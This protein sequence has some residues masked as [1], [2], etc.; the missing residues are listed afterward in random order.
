LPLFLAGIFPDRGKL[1]R[2]V[3]ALLDADIPSS[4]IS[5]AF[6]ET[7]EEDVSQRGELLEEHEFGALAVHSGWERLGWLSAARPA[8][9]DRIP[10]DIDAAIVTAGPLAIAIG[11]AQVGASAGGTVGSMSNFG[12]PLELSRQWFDR[13]MLGQVWVMVRTT[14]GEADKPREIFERYSPDLPAESLRHW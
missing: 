2:V 7:A 14:T 6:R 8:Y 4:E 3:T 5:V 12:F 1:E 11:G 10:P 13:I 9:R